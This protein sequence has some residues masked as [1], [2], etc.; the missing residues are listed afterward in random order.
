[1][2]STIRQRQIFIEQLGHLTLEYGVDQ[3]SPGTNFLGTQLL[4]IS[5][6]LGTVNPKALV[7]GDISELN[8]VIAKLESIA[9][10][11]PREDNC[12]TIDFNI[13]VARNPQ[14]CWKDV[15]L[16]VPLREDS[17]ELS[18]GNDSC[19]SPNHG[20]ES[21][22][23]QGVF[24]PILRDSVSPRSRF[25]SHNGHFSRL[26]NVQALEQQPCLGS[27][28]TLTT[29]LQQYTLE[30][31]YK[32]KLAHTIAQALWQFYDTELLYRKWDSDCILFMPE[33]HEGVQRVPI[34]PYVSIQFEASE[35]NADEYLSE[36]FLIHRY[37]RIL[38][39]A[40]VLVEIGLGK[41]LQ[42]E[43]C[44]NL[45]AQSNTDFEAAF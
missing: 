25:V 39:F 37:S 43:Q 36:A 22:L 41:P 20:Q 34:K 14:E 42:L 2:D 15:G 16:S 6:G 18:A 33:E 24:C 31:K 40:I 29:V 5:M 45:V 17:V 12:D 13:V 4:L 38:A 30:I 7:N 32:F 19:N 27:G 8:K 26:P 28:I 10:Q 44:D 1:M 3:E 9:K 23:G 35:E 11:K 21:D